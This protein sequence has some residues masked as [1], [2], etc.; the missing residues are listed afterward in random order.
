MRIRKV[1]ITGADD[2]TSIAWMLKT[3]HRYPFV[4][5]GI[6][7]AKSQVGVP[8]Y[9]GKDWLA[10]LTKWQAELTTSVHV[11]GRFV[12]CICEGDWTEL[13]YSHGE[14]IGGAKRVQLNFHAHV[15]KLEE[16]FFDTAK[17][18]SQETGFQLI[19]Q[20]YG[21]NDDLMQRARQRGI[22]AVPLFDRSGGAGVLPESWPVQTPGLYSGYAGGLG[23]ENVLDQI[24][25]IAAVATGDIWIDCETRV[26][27]PDDARL[28]E[29]AVESFLKQCS[30]LP[31]VG[32]SAVSEGGQGG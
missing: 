31:F 8:R 32:D 13:G 17:H 6:L 3:Q 24:E 15:H 23:P 18:I 27:T 21:V 9:P 16:P 28:D 7:V 20:L 26:R 29:S 12:R 30:E 4:E 10:G 22:D 11:C 1:T 25:K 19:F 14:L 5:W 2:Q